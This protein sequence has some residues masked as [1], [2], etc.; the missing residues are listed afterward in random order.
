[1][2]IVT[3]HVMKNDLQCL[4]CTLLSPYRTELSVFRW[5]VRYVRLLA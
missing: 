1:V 3:S 4:S 5:T 2:N